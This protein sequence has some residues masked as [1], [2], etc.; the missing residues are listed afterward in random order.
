[1]QHNSQGG[2]ARDVKVHILCLPTAAAEYASLF[3]LEVSAL[4][5]PCRKAQPAGL[6]RL[7]PSCHSVLGS[8]VTSSEVPLTR[9]TEVTPDCFFPFVVLITMHSGLISL[10]VFLSFFLSNETAKSRKPRLVHCCLH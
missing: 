9:A 1:M 4:Q 7:T 8:N 2:D 3:P 10:F 5:V 6:R